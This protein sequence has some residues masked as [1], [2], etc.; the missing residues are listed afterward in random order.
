MT[1]E[2]IKEG[3]CYHYSWSGGVLVKWQNPGTKGSGAY[4]GHFY[5]LY[6]KNNG[7]DKGNG[8]GFRDGVIRLATPEESA[9]LEACIKANGYVDAPKS[10]SDAELLA[11]AKRKYPVGTEVIGLGSTTKTKDLKYN[12]NSGK[13]VK[14]TTDQVQVQERNEWAQSSAIYGS[15][16]V[17]L[18][19]N[20]EW[21]EATSSPQTVK[22]WIPKIGDK[23]Q[24]VNLMSKNGVVDG[25][26]GVIGHV[27]VITKKGD[28]MYYLEPTCSGDCWYAHNLELVESVASL[29]PPEK[30]T[31]GLTLTSLPGKW[32]LLRTPTTAVEINKYFSNVWSAPGRFSSDNAYITSQHLDRHAPWLSTSKDKPT[33]FAEIT[34]E[35]FKMW[36]V[37]EP[38][39]SSSLPEKWCIKP[40]RT[41][42]QEIWE[43]LAEPHQDVRH[44]QWYYHYPPVSGMKYVCYNSPQAGYKVITHEQFKQWLLKYKPATT[45][46]TTMNYIEDAAIIPNTVKQ[47]QQV[48][49]HH[50]P[51]IVEQ[52][53]KKVKIISI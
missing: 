19:Y 6:T 17:Y 13:K 7:F 25:I 39:V 48:L 8:Y 29:S 45:T 9:H 23:V 46:M 35:Q 53:K 11:E 5:T 28:D 52:K 51:I 33:G 31:P 3:L 22:T 21:A 27:G 41:N 20:D 30:P 38:S 44:E 34:Y 40:D 15:D 26:N 32:C 42:L 10:M 49:R 2:D 16:N 43:T 12:I 47:V 24:I 14:I 4:N 1:R 37:G 18:Y 50:E 36:V